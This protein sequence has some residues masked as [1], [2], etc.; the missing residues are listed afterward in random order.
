MRKARADV[1][2]NGEAEI[3]IY[4]MDLQVERRIFFVQPIQPP[5]RQAV[6]G[7][8]GFKVFESLTAQTYQT[9]TTMETS[10]L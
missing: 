9:G 10:L 5:I 2:G 1:V 6:V 3:G 7:Q 8:D 4:F